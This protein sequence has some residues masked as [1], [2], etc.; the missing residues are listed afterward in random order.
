M[1]AG[2]RR[3]I[4]EGGQRFSFGRLRKPAGRYARDEAQDKRSAIHH[5]RQSSYSFRGGT[6]VR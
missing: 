6:G 3:D 1:N 5:Q 4:D 2:L